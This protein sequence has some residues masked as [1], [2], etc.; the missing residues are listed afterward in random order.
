MSAPIYYIKNGSL[1]FADKIVFEDIEL[2]LHHGDKVCLIGRNGCGKSSLMK[3]ING[4]YEL[5]SGDLYQDPKTTTSYLRQDS[6]IDL[7]VSI[8]EFILKDLGDDAK[9]KADIIFEKL[10]IEGAK[11]MSSLSG[12]QLRRASL[13]KALVE[14]PEIL[15]LDEPTNHLDIAAIEWLE[16]YVKSYPGSVVCISHD[17]AFLNNV[18]NKLWWIDR[19]VLRKSDKGFKYFEEWQEKLLEHE[20]ATLKKMQKKLDEENIWLSQGVTGRRKRNQKRLSD[21]RRLRET[22]REKTNHLASGK[23]KIESITTDEAKKTRFIIEADGLCFG[24]SSAENKGLIIKDFSFRVKKGEKIGLIGPNGSGKSTLIKL[25]LKELEPESGR[26]RHGTELDLSYFDQHRTD[27][28]PNHSLKQTLCP[29]GGD[30]VFLHDKTTHVVSYLK[31]FMFDPKMLNAKVSTLSGGEA[32]RLLLAKALI[33]PGNLFILDEPT[34]DLDM[35]TLEMLL[36]V[37]SDYT[38]TLIVVS[39][40]RDFLEKLVTRTL[41]FTPDQGILDII[42]GYDDYVKYY[43]KDAPVPV[44]VKKTSV[45]LGLDP[46]VLGNSQDPGIFANHSSKE[47]KPRKKLSYKDQRLLENIPSEIDALEA[48]IIAIEKEL[49]STTLYMKDPVK[50]GKLSEELEVSRSKIDELTEVWMKIEEML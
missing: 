49:G 10:Q 24:Y 21:L 23:Q 41:V 45:A 43:K 32:N 35:D 42:G 33:N 26:V 34:N 44:K 36:E 2:Y 16:D 37:L 22:M 3:V 38:G 1:R 28:N 18:T 17:R 50:F 27:L 20:E 4:D 11:I 14:E 15:L 46:K 8:Y 39:H 7:S 25:L 40:D 6:K 5:D 9:Y 19:G 48:R 29:S 31:S 13:A 30:Q 12:G 47:N